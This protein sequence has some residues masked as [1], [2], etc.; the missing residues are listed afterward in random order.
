MALIHDQQ[1]RVPGIKARSV[2]ADLNGSLFGDDRE[3]PECVLPLA[4][5]L[6]RVAITLTVATPSRRDRQSASAALAMNV[7]PDP[8]G[9]CKIPRLMLARY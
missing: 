6:N 7:F 8:A 9:A 3:V 2:T 4:F 1:I 5:L